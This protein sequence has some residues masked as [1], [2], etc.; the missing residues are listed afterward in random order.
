MDAWKPHIFSDFDGTIT[1]FDVGIEIFRKFGTLEP[2]YSQLSNGQLHIKEFWKLAFNEIPSTITLNEI[3]N[4]VAETVEI[5]QHFNEFIEF[6]IQKEIKFEILSDGFDFYIKTVLNKIIKKDI[7]FWSNTITKENGTY[8]PIFTFASESCECKNVGSCKRNIALSNLANDEILVYI[9]DGYSD[10]CMADYSD[11]V[12]AKKIL[13]RYCNEKKIPHFPYKTFN[14][15][16]FQL[17]KLIQRKELKPRRQAQ[18]KRKK[19]FE[20]E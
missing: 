13:A 15:I 11:I 19:A 17:E 1:N 10:F 20:I 12:F 4:F 5:D 6:C 18:L 7:P 8:L 3:C 16:R 14:D 9:G 2:Y